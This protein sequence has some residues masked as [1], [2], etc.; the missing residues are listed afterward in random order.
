MLDSPTFPVTA[1]WRVVAHLLPND[2]DWPVSMELN[3]EMVV[4]FCAMVKAHH[5]V[6]HLAMCSR[7]M[8]HT[9][10]ALEHDAYILTHLVPFFRDRRNICLEVA[11]RIPQAF[12]EH[13][14]AHGNAGAH[15]ALGVLQHQRAP[16][17]AYAHVC[18]AVRLQCGAAF[19]ALAW[20]L[21]PIY[22]WADAR[23]N[24]VYVEL[25]RQG[26]RRGDAESC[27]WYA[28][29]LSDDSASVCA[30]RPEQS[31]LNACAR[32]IIDGR[33]CASSTLEHQERSLG[34]VR[35][36]GAPWWRRYAL[37]DVAPWRRDGV[38]SGLPAWPLCAH[39]LTIEPYTVQCTDLE[40]L[41][42][43]GASLSHHDAQPLARIVGLL[44][45]LEACRDE[46]RRT[47]LVVEA[48]HALWDAPA[49]HLS[50]WSSDDDS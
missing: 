18:G 31:R 48:A 29:F 6:A 30:N 36:S 38:M 24:L 41:R 33:R 40:E 11:R 42:R 22:G 28:F 8:W 26:A 9:R 49:R 7:R 19:S 16:E 17:R 50:P 20:L 4:A 47:S 39:P 35:R 10:F 27:E 37:L 34:V 46:D 43:H 45:Q 5:D 2:G 23:I 1:L 25:F 21:V 32:C 15:L 14:A 3:L 12:L 13:A 44:T